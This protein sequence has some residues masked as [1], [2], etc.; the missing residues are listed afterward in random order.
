MNVLID[1]I[2]IRK[3]KAGVGVYAENLIDE[4]VR[5]PS[6]THFYVLAQSDDADLDYSHCSNVTM[7]RVP[8]MLFRKLPLRFLLEQAVLPLLLVR[9]RIDV[10]HSL[11]YSF[12]L[13]RFGTKQ[14][15]TVHDMT[16]FNMPE[17][18]VP[19]KVAYFRIFIRAA[20]RFA[21]KIIFVSHSTMKDCVTRLGPIKGS[22]QVIHL[23]KSEAFH[24]A[25]DKERTR[26]VRRKYAHG[27]EF[28]LYLGTIEPRKNLSRLIAAFAPVS[29]RHPGLLLLLAGEKGWMYDD[30]LASI[31]KLNLEYC[32]VFT[33]FVPEDEK[34]F[35]IGAAK[36]FVYPS[37]Y[38][39]F[40]IPVLE[41]LACGVPTLT[42][43][44]SSIP[45]VAGDAALLVD[46]ADVEAMSSGL[47]RV[48]SDEALR[49]RLRRES[50]RQ[51]A[52]FSWRRTAEL[53]L[54]AY[55]SVL[56]MPGRGCNVECTNCAEG[57]N[58]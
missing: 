30:L 2:A 16:F 41:A 52:R 47:E 54:G 36:A 21:D 17:V 5:D 49:D 46:P 35:L 6:S 24:P 33:G 42:S 38:E 3:S 53:T 55:H 57:D 18:H 11:H 12:P 37:L 4:L 32:V 1:A 56:S 31:R 51:A 44:V 40:G 27:S 43:R 58:D 25:L 45:E 29:A 50:V 26:Q 8:A 15:V 20:V 34:P 13:V 14:I 7:V 9:H 48:I 23:G 22:A 19:V 39:G 10:L 28:V